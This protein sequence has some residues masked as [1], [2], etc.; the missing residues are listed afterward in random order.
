MTMFPGR[1]LNLVL[2][3]VASVVGFWAWTVI[4]PMGALYTQQLE[5]NSAQ[6]SFL[7]AMPILVG[8][9]GRIIVGSLTDRYGG[10]VMFTLVG[11][12]LAQ[13][14]FIHGQARFSADDIG[15]PGQIR[16]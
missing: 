16:R 10:R 5:L 6:T 4:A 3:T 11:E 9:L 1:T 8:A 2:A 15:F 14:G 13:V 7:V 12:R